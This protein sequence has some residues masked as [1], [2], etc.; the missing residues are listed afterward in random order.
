[1][2][3]AGALAA[4]VAW[5]LAGGMAFAD[6]QTPAEWR[7]AA[8]QDLDAIRTHISADTPVGAGAAGPAY[9]AWLQQGYAEAQARLPRVEDRN[10]Y[11]YALAAYV[12]GFHDPHLSLS[13]NQALPA[14]RWPGFIATLQR[15]D[16]VV[17]WRDPNDTAAPPLGARIVSCDGESLEALMQRTVYAFVI[18][19]RLPESR[20]RATPRMFLDA[21]NPYAPPPRACAF[22][23]PG[24]A[25]TVTLAWRA[26][27]NP[28]AAFNAAFSDAGLGP[29]A[30][31]G[32]STPAPGV[33]W[34]GAPTF[35]AEGENGSAL[36][37]LM[38]T[39]RTH[40][41][42]LRSGRAIVIDLRGN[43]GGSSDW[44][45]RLAGAVF[46]DDFIARRPL[47]NPSGAALWRASTGNLAYWQ[48]FQTRLERQRNGTTRSNA[49]S[50]EVTNGL[51]RA[52]D[53]REP[54][55]RQG[56]SNSPPGG[57]ITQ[58]RP[59]G[60]SPIPAHVYVLSNGSCA[61]A[62]LDF[63]DIVLQIPGVTLIGA[64]T[65]ADTLLA[66]VRSETLPSG[67]ARFLFA[68]KIMAGRGRAALE[69]YEPDIAYDGVW[70]DEAVRAWVLQTIEQGR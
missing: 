47:A 5:A 15:G 63:A 14:P 41:A 67:Q 61:S 49:Q 36:G 8:A 26:L 50:H 17:S 57:G 68:Q 59:R 45:T 12:N 52:L 27:P 43:R 60:Q 31:F 62:C 30:T 13:P 2:K 44:A 10:G 22:D 66:D 51:S 35:L 19:P 3:R 4:L 42:E 11:Y 1:M 28:P 9:D 48:A 58:R 16:V 46:G 33:A 29:S 54:L 64:A 56:A 65:S 69:Y 24:G 6:P 25:R 18:D 7:A 32:L 38:D 34:V 37:T 40:G 53:R 55:W 23:G 39:L 21:G 20:R 70:T